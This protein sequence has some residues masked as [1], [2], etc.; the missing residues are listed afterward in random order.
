MKIVI[1]G[2]VLVA[3]VARLV[4][5]D[6]R[7]CKGIIDS[8]NN[9]QKHPQSIGD[10]KQ[11]LRQA[12]EGDITTIDENGKEWTVKRMTF[13]F[14]IQLQKF[15]IAYNQLKFDFFTN[16][17]SESSLQNLQ[18]I[19]KEMYSLKKFYLTIREVEFMS[20]I[21]KMTANQEID[22]PV[23]PKVESC[24]FFI[25]DQ[26]KPTTID[27]LIKVEKIENTLD[28]GTSKSSGT[29]NNLLNNSSISQRMLFYYRL[30]RIIDL[31]RSKG[32]AHRNIQLSNI[33]ADKDLNP[34]LTGFELSKF[35]ESNTSIK[36]SKVSKKSI[37]DVNYV[38]SDEKAFARVISQLESIPIEEFEQS[39]TLI[40]ELKRFEN[41]DKSFQIEAE[42][43]EFNAGKL[44]DHDHGRI[45]QFIEMNK[46]KP[47]MTCE[48]F[49]DRFENKN[50]QIAEYNGSLSDFIKNILKIEE[51]E[52]RSTYSW[53][54]SKEMLVFYYASCIVEG[55]KKP[56]FFG[57]SCEIYLMI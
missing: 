30:A 34:Y 3:I 50:R 21:S 26:Y 20:L 48:D 39:Y 41:S 12:L 38:E 54:L 32:I 27:L 43:N 35:I 45:A 44:S 25:K 57:C 6:E 14:S 49:L 24:I 53:R 19:P 4:A 42:I 56:C 23:I 16:E 52:V 18:L 55:P 8:K 36:S 46:Y 33:K 1:R 10:H 51:D 28:Y 11:V 15:L 9:P 37:V 5:G 13:D 31:L 7:F 17:F 22:Y 40:N 47:V 2:F 29:N